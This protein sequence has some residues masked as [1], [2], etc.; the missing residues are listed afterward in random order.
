M[1]PRKVSVTLKIGFISKDWVIS[2][3]EEACQ[4]TENGTPWF[5]PE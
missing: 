4:A 5:P 2:E 3:R 1:D